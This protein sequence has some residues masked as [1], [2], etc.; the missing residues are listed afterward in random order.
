MNAFQFSGNIVYVNAKKSR[1]E[2]A[3]VRILNDNCKKR[4]GLTIKAFNKSA[5]ILKDL[6]QKGDFVEVLGHIEGDGSEGNEV[7]YFADSVFLGPKKQIKEMDITSD[8]I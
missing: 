3:E 7:T 1:I 4:T 6:C 2:F 8:N 5:K